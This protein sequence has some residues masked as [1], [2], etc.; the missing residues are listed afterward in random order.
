MRC[1]ACRRLEAEDLAL[2]S[3][4]ECGAQQSITRFTT[5]STGRR[6]AAGEFLRALIAVRQVD[7]AEDLLTALSRRQTARTG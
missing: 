3:P 5:S 1:D 2:V 6:E 4:T 7:P